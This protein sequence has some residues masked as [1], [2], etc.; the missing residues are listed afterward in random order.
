VAERTQNNGH[1]AANGQLL[2]QSAQKPVS[3]RESYKV[4]PFSFWGMK[5][6]L[7]Y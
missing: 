1:F 6:R 3:K 7:M 2:A 5:F 4:A